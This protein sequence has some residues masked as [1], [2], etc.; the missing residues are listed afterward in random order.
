MT[1]E[2]NIAALRRARDAWNRGDSTNTWR[3]TTRASCSTATRGWNRAW[4]ASAS[5]T[6]V[7]GRLSPA[8][9]SPSTTSWRR[10]TGWRCGSTWRGSTGAR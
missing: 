6:V 3:S 1:A 10:A 4:T 7:S 9:N 2:E 5:S 8:A